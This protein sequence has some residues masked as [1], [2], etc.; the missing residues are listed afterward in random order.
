MGLP[1]IAT[2]I[3][4]SLDQ[5]ADGVTGLLIPPGDPVPLADAIEKLMVN[6]ELRRRMGEAGVERIHTCFS[7]AQMTEK[8]ERLF[9][10][11]IAERTHR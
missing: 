8:I 4:G 5:V 2:N 6:P 11:A 3:G 1:V 9:D 7:L 10:D